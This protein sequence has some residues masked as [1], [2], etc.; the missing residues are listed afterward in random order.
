MVS[1][2][3]LSTLE[4]LPT[5]IRVHN[6]E[7]VDTAAGKWKDGGYGSGIVPTTDDDEDEDDQ[8]G[9]A[10]SGSD[11]SS[12]VSDTYSAISSD[13]QE[14]EDTHYAGNEGENDGWLAKKTQGITPSGIRKKLLRKTVR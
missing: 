6:G 11:T 5:F 12:V 8:G 2:N 13:L 14:N 3:F 9:A 7:Y 10:N 4:S 1:P